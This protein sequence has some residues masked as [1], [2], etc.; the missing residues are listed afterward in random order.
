M[1]HIGNTRNA[2]RLRIGIAKDAAFGFYYPGDLEAMENY[3]AELVPFSPLQDE[4]LPVTDG[5]FIGGGFPETCI[6]ALEANIAMRNCIAA[7]IEA[8]KPVYAECGGLMYL[9]RSITWHGNTGAMV[10]IIA[11]DAVMHERPQGRGYVRVQETAACPW[12]GGI[13]GQELTAHEF[14]YSRIENLPT[15]LT[16]A[17]KVLRGYGIDGVHDGIVYKNLLA[18][19][20][21]FRDV[22]GHHWILRFLDHV[23]DC[24]G[25]NV[26]PG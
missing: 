16:F 15:N 22:W 6:A 5:L 25:H 17:F 10:G 1:Q 23:R 26:A 12:G 13:V 11:A 18:G 20:T 2:R 14:H 3:G 24:V 8:G 19:F 4:A 9:T 7:Y 21:H